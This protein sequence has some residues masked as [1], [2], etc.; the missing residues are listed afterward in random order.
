MAIAAVLAAIYLIAEPPSADLAAQAF[1]ADQFEAHGF[2]VWTNAWYGGIEL[3]GYSPLF[4]PLAAVLGVR[5]VGA[6]AAVA[7]AG[8]FGALVS[9][10]GGD[11]G[12]GRLGAIWF[13]AATA[14]NLFTG[15]LTFALGVAVGLAALLALQRRRPGGASILA[16]LTVLAS[17][18]A[19]LFLA[20]AGA[21]V[22]LSGGRARGRGEGRGAIA[23]AAV[24][25]ATIALVAYAFPVSGVEPFV[26]SAF[27]SIAGFTVVALVLLPHGEQALRRGIAI[28]GGLALVLFLFDT[29]IGGNVARLGA[30]FGGPVLA[31]VLARRRPLALALVALPLLAWQLAAPI[32]DVSDASG[33]PSIARAFHQPLVDELGSLA[34]GAPSRV[35]VLPT[36]NRW[37]SVYV[38]RSFPLARGW[39]RQA[40][41]DDFDLFQD[42]NLTP[43]A[44][45]AWLRERAVSYVA[46][47][48]GVDLDYLADDEAALIDA[49]LPYLAL[50]WESPDW[51]LYRVV[52]GAAFVATPDAPLEPADGARLAA[53]GH[54]SFE[55]TADRAG[56]YLVR[57]RY[58]RYWEVISGDACI[59]PE[60]DWTLVEAKAPSLIGVRAGFSA[61]ALLGT[62]D[63]CG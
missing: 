58:T 55:L 56:S 63:Q 16:A 12:T 3:P 44:Y 32:R 35:E 11:P 57:E 27:W 33:D 8:L 25:L 26:A 22:A 5:L 13:G 61:E 42:G 14:V 39:L 7:A 38:A 21:G 45:E 52:G 28:Y 24:A 20:I 48:L 47:P 60:G 30:L 51:R 59:E 37:E 2:A 31:V 17:P 62:S 19:G 23:M 40:E 36:R 10:R 34:A 49:G 9:G 41:S 46:V 54:D 43:E 18:I 50:V 53:L 29:A 1:R 15:R 6:L 4:P